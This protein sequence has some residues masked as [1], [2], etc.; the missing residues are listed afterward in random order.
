MR[1]ELKQSSF[2]LWRKRVISGVSSK[3]LFR[4][5]KEI[6]RFKSKM[7]RS[8]SSNRISKR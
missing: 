1:K 6:T 3:H 4:R 7:Q 5:E 2:K 8:I